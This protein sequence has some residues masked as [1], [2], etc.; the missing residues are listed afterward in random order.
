MTALL[1]AFSARHA[2]TR[3]TTAERVR[4]ASH[5]RMDADPW[6]TADK[7][8]ERDIDL[9]LAQLVGVTQGR[10]SK[11]VK[12][13]SVQWRKHCISKAERH[14]ERRSGFSVFWFENSVF[15]RLVYFRLAT[16]RRHMAVETPTAQVK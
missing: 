2:Y 16:I 5:T 9:P 4:D 3:V 13:E 10:I 15:G 6:F 8:D 7:R 11:Q 12:L 14:R 1:T